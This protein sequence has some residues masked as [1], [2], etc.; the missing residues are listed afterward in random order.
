MVLVFWVSVALIAYVYVGYPAML[1]SGVAAAARGVSHPRSDQ[2]SAAGK[3]RFESGVSIVIAARNEGARLPARIDNLL[4]LDYP[5]AR[6][7]IIVVS[8]GSTDDTLDVLA[9]VSRLSSTRRRSAGGKALALNAG[10]ER[11]RASTSSCLPTRVRCSRPTRC[12][13]WWRRSLIPRSAAVTG[14]LLLDA[15]IAPAAAATAN[16]GSLASGA[17]ARGTP[18]ADRRARE[19][20]R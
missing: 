11:A 9:A 14:E 7:Q 1:L 6:R 15:E 19:R 8:D 5:A 2:P 16:A 13:S 12:A 10:V 18:T 3:P 17:P 20:R 4:S